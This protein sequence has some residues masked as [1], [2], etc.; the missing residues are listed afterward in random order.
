[1]KLRVSIDVR[2]SARE[3]AKSFFEQS[4]KFSKKAE[5]CRNAIIEAKRK[6]EELEKKQEVAEM[7]RLERRVALQKKG[8]A[9]RHWFEKFKWFRTSGGRLAIGGRD[10]TTN[11]VLV[12]KHMEEGDVVFHADVPGSPF[13]ILKDGK[14]ASEEELLG[15]ARFT[16]S[17]SRAWREGLGS[18]D[19]YWVNPDQVSKTPP[20]GEYISRG[21]FMIYGRK[22]YYRNTPLGICIGFDGE[23]V[24][25]GPLSAVSS[26]AKTFCE[27]TPGAL[28]QSAAAKKIVNELKL[29]GRTGVLDEIQRLLPAGGTNVIPASERN[30]RR[31]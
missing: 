31:S 22:N 16:A 11:E 7:R 3:N 9:E 8:P 24:I 23:N 17:H 6:L 10:A 28:S 1:M 19:V 12:K 29:Q 27:I 30:R 5:G 25:S 4:K 13:L 15:A 20:A 18:V 26:A 21:S 14:N 2:K